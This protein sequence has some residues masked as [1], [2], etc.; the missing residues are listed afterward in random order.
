MSQPIFTKK[1]S[2][3]PD[4]SISPPFIITDFDLSRQSN[5]MFHILGD[6]YKVA[7]FGSRVTVKTINGVLR[8]PETTCQNV[9]DF[10]KDIYI[11]NN[12]GEPIHFGYRNYSGYG[13]CV[14]MGLTLRNG[15]PGGVSISFLEVDR[16]DDRTVFPAEPYNMPKRDDNYNGYETDITLVYEKQYRAY[17]VK[18]ASALQLMFASRYSIT[19]SRK[20]IIYFGDNPTQAGIEYTITDELGNFNSYFN[21]MLESLKISKSADITLTVGK[22]TYPATVVQITSKEQSHNVNFLTYNISAIL[23]V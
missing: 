19:N 17:P 3:K 7:S 18:N 20:N 11:G 13:Y 2:G 23:G 22:A 8:N 9:I 21:N 14:G 15:A 6:D 5:T 1:I 16:Q 10:Y 12:Y 4:E